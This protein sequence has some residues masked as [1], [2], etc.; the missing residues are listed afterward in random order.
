MAEN[1]DTITKELDVNMKMLSLTVE[2]VEKVITKNK[3]KEIQKKLN[4]LDE[5]I[6]LVEN[7]RIKI[8]TLMFQEDKTGEEVSRYGETIDAELE[9][10]NEKIDQL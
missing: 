1:M 7:C 9:I 5:K 6:E 2:S 10:Y 3:L 8:Q 4:L